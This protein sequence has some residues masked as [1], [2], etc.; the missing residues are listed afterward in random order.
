MV[1]RRDLA[2]S[3]ETHEETDEEEVEEVSSETFNER[4]AAFGDK[5][6]DLF[7]KTIG[8]DVRKHLQEGFTSIL[9]GRSLKECIRTG[10]FL[11]DV[12]SFFDKE[13]APVL[14]S[15]ADTERVL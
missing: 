5:R 11:K 1:S 9:G 4:K 2:R 14:S 6:D 10:T 7:Y 8:R 13:I 15:G 12:K 3:H